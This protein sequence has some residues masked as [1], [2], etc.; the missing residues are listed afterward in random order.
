MKTLW[1]VY[2]RRLERLM[3]EEQQVATSLALAN[4]KGRM[5]SLTC[6]KERISRMQKEL[7][8]V[9]KSLAKKE[10]DRWLINAKVFM[11]E[12]RETSWKK[13]ITASINGNYCGYDIACAMRIMEDLWLNN[14]LD[15]SL[16][17]LYS[18]R[19]IPD[20]YDRIRE[21]VLTYSHKGLEFY[22]ASQRGPLTRAQEE[23]LQQIRQTK[24]ALLV[25]QKVIKLIPSK[26]EETK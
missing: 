5:Q 22:E 6:E 10:K 2:G 9:L 25:P 12:E 3:A 11:E 17:I 20:V 13:E 21:L 4:T 16:S 1:D 24:R 19:H 14:H 7:A 8:P 26:N 15:R 18:G 23:R